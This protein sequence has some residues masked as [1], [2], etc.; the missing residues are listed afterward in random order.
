MSK[1][2]LVTLPFILLLLDLWPLRRAQL[3][4]GQKDLWLRL[5]YEKIPLL[6]LSA[7]SSIVTIMIQW[8]SG[9]VS[10]FETIP[11]GARMANMLFSYTAYIAGIFW[12]KDLVAYYPYNPLP[13]WLA[14]GSLMAL[15][16]ATFIAFRFARK[17]PHALV[18]WLWYLITL[19]PVIGLIQVGDQARADRYM[20]LPSIGLFVIAA[21]SIPLLLSRLRHRNVVL[22]SAAAIMICALTAAA[23]I[24]IRHWEDDLA[25][26]THTVEKRGTNNYLAHTQLGSARADRGEL[27]SAI[28]Q[29]T[30]A[31]RINP[32]MQAAR[33]KLGLAYF[34]QKRFSEALRQYNETIRINPRSALAYID[35]GIL[36]GTQ[37]KRGQ[38]IEDFRT[39]LKINPDNAEAHY[40]LGYSLADDGKTSEAI[41]HFHEALRINPEH[42]QACNRLGTALALQGK[43]G[44]AINQYARAVNIEPNFWEARINLGIALMHQN[45]DSEALGHFLEALRINP[46]LAQVHNN[47]GVILSNQGR[48]AEAIIHF[49]EALRL[50]PDSVEIQENLRSARAVRGDNR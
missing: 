16:A 45:R 44:E 2:M 4:T 20:Y 46:N 10:S 11:L 34:K 31:L 48:T 1:P 39:A 28:Q 42:A 40:N 35:R 50:Y 23:R 32:E 27:T 14:G 17:Q 15:A 36:S 21:W 47:V 25:L 30:E 7:A 43:L 33:L 22:F 5:I 8:R 49:N 26:W 9:A 19:L 6:A 29:Y 13:L 3:A 18:G 12:P 37:G 41:A 24:Q 38:A